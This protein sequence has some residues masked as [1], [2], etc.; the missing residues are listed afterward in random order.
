MSRRGRRAGRSRRRRPAPTA[1]ALAVKSRRARSSGSDAVQRREVDAAALVHDAP[2]A[3]ALRQRK[4][5]AAARARVRPG[6]LRR[7]R[8]PRRRPSRRPAGR[9]G[10][11]GRRRRRS[12]RRR[13][14]S[15]RPRRRPAPRSSRRHLAVAAVGPVAQAARDLVA[16]RAGRAGQR[17]DRRS[18]GR[19]A[20]PRRPALTRRSSGRI[21]ASWSIA[22]A[23]T[24]H[25]RPPTTTCGRARRRPRE[26][27]GVAHRHVRHPQRAFGPDA[28]AVAARLARAR[29][30]APSA[31]RSSRSAPA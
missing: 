6:G 21:T 14:R 23:P 1:T 20:S 22:T 9:A 28:P 7:D 18:R 3:V 11:R 4:R 15:A 17:L 16:D 13:R 2:G 24:V 12:S 25:G 27:V 29:A 19:S 10:G 30:R 26:A 31:P 8:P 5:R